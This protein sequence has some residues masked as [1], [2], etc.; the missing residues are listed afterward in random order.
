MTINDK[1]L[2]NIIEKAEHA[3]VIL[4]ANNTPAFYRERAARELE[5][6]IAEHREPPSDQS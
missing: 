6:A 1:I 2:E 5:H 3:I 4:K